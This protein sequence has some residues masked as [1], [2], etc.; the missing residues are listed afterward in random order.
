MEFIDT[1]SFKEIASVTLILF[2]VIDILGSIPLIINIKQQAGGV[3]SGKA[4]LVAA[5]IMFMF[6][7]LGDNILRLFGIDYSSFAIAGSIILFL[8]GIEMLLGI[9]LFRSNA[10]SKSASIVPLAFPIIAGAGTMTTLSSLRAVYALPNIMIGIIVN[11]I[12][13]YV[14]LK[15]TGW[16]AE[17]LGS[18]GIEI[19]RKVFG[20]ILLAIAIKLFKDNLILIAKHIME[21]VA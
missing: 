12:F 5:F 13:V 8:L 11:I 4:T 21:N 15:N 18:G 19:M 14:V 1:I 3:E 2:S 7:F 16:I 6:L 17:K 10:T 20:M 9:H